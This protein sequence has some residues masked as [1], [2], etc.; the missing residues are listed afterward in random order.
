MANNIR[1]KRSVSTNSPVSLLQGELAY[2]ESGSPNGIGELFIGVSGPGIQKIASL[3]GGNAAEPNQT[4]TTG[5]GLDGADAGST[6]NITVDFAPVEL[7]NVAPVAA[8]QFVFNDAT[9]DS[10]KKQVASSIP[11]S[12]FSDDLVKV[13]TLTAGI[14]IVNNGTATDPDIA[15]D[16][17]ELTDMVAGVAGTTELIINDAG[18]ESRKAI[19]EI[20]LGTF[21][22]DLGWTDDVQAIHGDYVF[23]TTT[24]S[25]DPGAGT[26][27]YNNATPGSVTALYID[28]LQ[29]GA[30]GSYEYVLANLA[31]NDI[32][33]IRGVNDPTDYLICQVSGS[34][35][36]NTGWWTVPVTVLFSGNLPANSDDIQIDV[37]W[38][39]Q[40]TAGTVASV[41]AGTGLVNTGTASAVVLD[42]DF[43]ELADLAGGSLVGTDELI[44]QDGGTTESRVQINE[45]S[46]GLFDNT[47]TEYVSENDTLVVADWNWVL[48]EDTMSSDSAVHVPTQQSVKAYV[49]SAVTGG[50]VYQGGFDPTAGAGAG[51]PDLDTITSSTGDTYTVTVAG[52]YNWTTGS[53]VLEVGDVL[54]AESDGVLNDVADWTIVQNNIGAASET[55]AGY[56][57]L[58]TQAEVDGET[59]DTRA[60]TTLKLH[61]TTFDG[62]SF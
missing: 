44:V 5:L 10:P 25:A 40:G 7:T 21:N 24:T 62:G 36:D 51:S 26:L 58:A 43:S 52:T 6:G 20:D 33:T 19:S 55:E 53:A 18:T 32:I 4:I 61:N 27:R 13:D 48:D 46:V 56:I 23:D 17:T 28:D 22:N 39:S 30:I 29:N 37:Q 8:D 1:I 41:T 9:D 34:T 42:L 45:I 50:L 3:T 31:T 47:T 54:I 12:I 38:F 59:D 14:G 16:F 60:V 57:E 15:L 49:D 2:S 35:T 11:L